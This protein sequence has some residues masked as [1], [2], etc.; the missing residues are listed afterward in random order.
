MVM[1]ALGAELVLTAPEK[2][3]GGAVEKAEELVAGN[4]DAFMLQQF[5]NPANVKVLQIIPS[6]PPLT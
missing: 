6:S 5:N 2:S 3:V 4:P 1:L